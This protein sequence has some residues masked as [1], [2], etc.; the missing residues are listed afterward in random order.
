MNNRIDNYGDKYGGQWNKSN[1]YCPECHV[2]NQP[3][4]KNCK[5][6]KVSISATARIPR[7]NAS[8]KE[9]DNFYNKFVLQEDLKEHL[10]KKP[11][12]FKYIKEMETF[13]LQN[14]IK[15]KNKEK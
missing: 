6:K 4:L 9:W 13:R 14:K 15:K 3:H 7:K 5:G 10:N 8:K 11:K 1:V 2:T 12:R